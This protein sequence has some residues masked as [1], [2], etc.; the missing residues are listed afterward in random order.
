MQYS[1]SNTTICVIRQ[2]EDVFACIYIGYLWV[3]AEETDNIAFASAEGTRGVGGFS[4]CIFLYLESHKVLPIKIE[5]LKVVYLL[6]F[7]SP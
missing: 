2:G 7:L 6:C 4:L 3:G 5:Y 1:V